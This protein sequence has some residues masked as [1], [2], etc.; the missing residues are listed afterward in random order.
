M[1]EPLLS[2][3][4]ANYNNPHL[5]AKCME[6]IDVHM[7]GIVLEV[8]IVDNNSKSFGNRSRLLLIS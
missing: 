4:I 5:I 7:R 6:T 8:I 2:I 1:S 3:V